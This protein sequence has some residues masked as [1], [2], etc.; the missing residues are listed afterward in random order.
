MLNNWF[1]LRGKIEGASSFIY[2]LLGFVITIILWWMLAELFSEKKQVYAEN[3]FNATSIDSVQNNQNFV[4]D[5]TKNISTGKF[6]KVYPL[7]PRP[8]KV[9][10]SF[11]DLFQKDK[12]I[13]NTIKSV[14]LNLQGYFWAILLAIPIGLIIGLFPIFNSL[15]S[16]Q[17]DAL[18]YLPLSALT[19]LFI[20]WFG[21]GDPMKIAFLAVGI[22]V[23]LIPVVVQR[24][25]ELED[26]Y[27][28][29]AYTMGASKWQLIKNVF[30]PG[31]MTKL[32]DDIRVLTAI[33]WTYIIIAELLNKE[34]GI[35]SLIYTKSRQ[36]QIDKVFALLIIIVFIGL[37]QDKLFA[38]IDHMI[39]PHK[40]YKFQASG[41]AEGRIGVFALIAAIVCGILCNYFLHINLLC[42][43]AWLLGATGILA[44]LYA[45]FILSKS[46]SK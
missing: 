25:S 2:P 18:R 3:N 14:W 44:L 34:A 32:V 46:T 36:G 9:L 19:G 38:L 5:T 41:L 20:I 31:I 23:Y 7:L 33:S 26:V 16:K 8:D 35:G 43:V 45:Y 24:I 40:Y 11:K 1:K 27:P 10:F 30:F 37:I 6:E 22:L 28:Q 21:L 29:T 12:L 13:P 39:N 15:F 17:I 4:A 42:T